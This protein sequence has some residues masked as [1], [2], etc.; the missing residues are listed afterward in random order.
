[1]P[2]IRELAARSSTK[3]AAE[4]SVSSGLQSCSEMR[5]ALQ[6]SRVKKR[7]SILSGATMR[8]LAAPVI[9]LPDVVLEHIVFNF[10]KATSMKNAWEVCPQTSRKQ[11]TYCLRLENKG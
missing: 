9:V 5:T 4:P 7:P 3:L 1:V 10:Q 11:I 2:R 8:G 6:P